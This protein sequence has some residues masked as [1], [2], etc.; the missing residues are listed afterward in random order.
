MYLYA[1]APTLERLTIYDNQAGEY[2]GGIA[3]YNASPRLARG[4]TVYSNAADLGGG[5]SATYASMPAL[6]DAWIHSNQA[7]IDGGGCFVGQDSAP[8]LTN[9]RI[10]ANEARGAEARGGGIV[11]DDSDGVL[12][13]V[14]VRGN[15]SA[16][17][18]GGLSLHWGSQPTLEEVILAGNEAIEG[19]G[20]FIYNSN[21]VLRHLVLA[22]NAAQTDGGG[23]YLLAAGAQLSDSILAFNT[24]AR[25]P[26]VY[27]GDGSSG[28]SMQYS[29][30]WAGSG[31]GVTGAT[32]GSSSVVADPRFVA[33]S[34]G[35][36]EEADYRLEAGSPAIDA[37]ASGSG[38]ADPD[39]SR[40]DLGA[41]GGPR[42]GA[43]DLD[44]DGVAPAWNVYGTA[45][46]S[47]ADCDD[48]DASVRNCAM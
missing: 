26:T 40:P 1:A 10:D 12:H 36:W 22:G 28:T 39:D 16:W 46:S 11:F 25:G 33:S 19:G 7:R 35:E 45:G 13:N 20:A 2:G 37:G 23:L 4:L 48:E 30:F 32:P 17:R 31:A 14:V 21:P 15:R 3:F 44:G 34:T 42:A 5:L 29:L 38:Q 9:V 6:E 24:A 41:W 47:G 27:A 18:G 8:T 43:W